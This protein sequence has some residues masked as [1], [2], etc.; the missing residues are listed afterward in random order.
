MPP[1]AAMTSRRGAQRIVTDVLHA[2]CGDAGYRGMTRFLVFAVM[3]ATARGA[4]A[5]P[6]VLPTFICGESASIVHV[7]SIDESCTGACGIR[8]MLVDDL[9]RASVMTTPCTGHVE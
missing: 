1:A 6:A 7:A 8:Y 9:D 3:L 2:R 4:S 5:G